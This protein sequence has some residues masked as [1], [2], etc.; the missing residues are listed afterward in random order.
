MS[1]VDSQ[2][3]T[4]ATHPFGEAAERNDQVTSLLN[5]LFLN[6]DFSVSSLT[7]EDV[8]AL[9]ELDR[10]I[11][12]RVKEAKD[13]FGDPHVVNPLRAQINALLDGYAGFSSPESLKVLTKF[14]HPPPV[15]R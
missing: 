12:Q 15:T 3:E 7:P 6:K 1:T 4:N 10:K 5:G 9:P 2:Q 11:Y 14:I 8:T 13:H